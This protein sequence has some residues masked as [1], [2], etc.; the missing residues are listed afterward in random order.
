M[1]CPHCLKTW[2]VKDDLKKVAGLGHKLY[3]LELHKSPEIRQLVLAK[4]EGI[5]C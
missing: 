3:E 5:K 1:T 4:G 2:L